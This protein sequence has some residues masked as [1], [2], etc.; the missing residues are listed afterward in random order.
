MAL[1]PG[2]KLGAYE[3]QAALGAGGMGEVYRAR[4]TAL[5]RDVALKI[6]SGTVSSDP[7]RLRRFKQEAQA[8]A[9]LNHPNILSVFYV[10]EDNGTP[11]LVSELLEG[12]T[13]RQVLQAGSVPIRKTV[14]YAIQISAGLAAAHSKGIVHRDLKPE[15]IFLTKDGRI[16]ILDFGLAKLVQAADNIPAEVTQT[17]ASEAGIVLG[18]MG[19]MSPEQ[20]CGGVIDHR[21]DIFSLGL[22]L[23]EMLSGARAFHRKSGAE[24]MAAILKEEPPAFD[25]SRGIPPALER[26]VQHCLEKEPSLRFQSAQDLMFDLESISSASSARSVPVVPARRGMKWMVPAL[27]LIAGLGLGFWTGTLRTPR[28]ISWHRLTFGKGTIDLARFAPDGQI[29]VYS[30]RWNGNAPDVFVTRKESPESRSL[31][32]QGAQLMAVSSRGE[33]AALQGGG[34]IGLGMYNGTLVRVP[35]EGGTPREVRDDVQFADWT[36]DGS[37]LAI[38]H[39]AGG[40]SLLDFPANHT[41]LRTTGFFAR[42]RISPDGNQIAVFEYSNRGFDAGA[43]LTVGRGGEKRVLSAG[44]SDLTGLAWSPSGSEVWFSGTRTSGAIAL[45]AVSLTGRE[46]VIARAPGDV[47]L[48][49][50]ARDGRVLLATERWTAEIYGLFPSGTEERELSWF[51]FSLLD[52]LTPDGRYVLFNEAGEGGGPNGG[53]Y[54]RST[55]GS[56]PIR[57]GDGSCPA[58]SPDGAFAA[59]LG[60]EGNGS[61]VLTPTK[62]GTPRTLPAERMT[63][64][65]L[66]YSLDG[67]YFLET[68][69]QPGHG[70]QV[71]LRSTDGQPSKAVTPEGVYVAKLSPDAKQVAALFADGRLE[72]YPIDGGEP[73]HISGTHP[74]DLLVGWT[75]DAKSLYLVSERE[76]AFQ[77]FR[78]DIATGR[79]ELWKTLVPPDR[80]GITAIYPIGITADDKHYAYSLQ[81]RLDDL[82]LVSGIK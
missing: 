40:F 29:L 47:V 78:V 76:T 60:S 34:L 28:E 73:M 44:W 3:I 30:A 21:S 31:G 7:E 42:P 53:A 58:I 8:T 49:D 37:E 77:V 59:C 74:S 64:S 2:V 24:T 57:L 39:E 82:Y 79:R 67:R 80:A 71:F 72:V 55:D 10:G 27:L 81:R 70:V 1:T 69:S 6:I 32:L 35:L 62:V 19:Y 48:K 46:R 5:N 54:I 41:V 75:G 23:Y 56:P 14:E 68:G 63:I 52:D 45:N 11:Y 25:I 66:S 4:D 17:I 20:V 61:I 38:V 65:D 22:I 26:I 13:L 18:T 12:Q 43:V 36:P 16:K 15:N 33:I 9:A 51:D 50:V